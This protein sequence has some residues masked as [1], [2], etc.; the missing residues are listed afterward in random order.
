MRA[1]PSAAVV[2]AVMIGDA[3]VPAWL[4]LPRLSPLR[5]LLLRLLLLR[6]LSFT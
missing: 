3:A 1:A 4:R 6:G 5:L 2:A